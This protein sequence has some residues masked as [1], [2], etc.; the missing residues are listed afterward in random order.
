MLLGESVEENVRFGR[1]SVSDTDI[2]NALK[3]AGIGEEELGENK[4]LGQRGV[5]ASGGQRQRIAIARALAGKPSLLLLDDCTAALDAQKEDAFWENLRSGGLSPLTLV[6]THREATVKQSEM[7]LFVSNGKLMD[8]GIHSE[9]LGSN[10]E[11]A[12]V[13]RGMESEESNHG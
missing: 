9:L 7:V 11:Y 13:I 4:I 5:G 10:P 1:E 12:R 3:V 6:V 8:T 2:E